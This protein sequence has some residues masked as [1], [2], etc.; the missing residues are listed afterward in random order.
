MPI[1]NF[2]T[3]VEVDLQGFLTVIPSR[4][5]GVN[6]HGD[7]VNH[8][9][10]LSKDYGANFFD[11]LNVDFD[12]YVEDEVAD[13]RFGMSGMGITNSVEDFQDLAATDITVLGQSRG[14]NV[15]WIRL[16]RGP[17]LAVDTFIGVDATPYYCTMTRPAG[18]DSVTVKVYDDAGRTA[19]D[20][21]DTLVVAGYGAT[22]YRYSMGFI[23]NNDP[24]TPLRMFNGYT[25]NM[26]LHVARPASANMAAKMIAGKLI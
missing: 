5:T 14:A 9:C 8:D 21:L 18:N 1:E 26:D 20:L 22:K 10:L 15:V 2:A 24:T 7:A 11:E 19:P 13:A 23:N 4:A 3:Y 12:I 25:Q 17:S 6:V 16:F